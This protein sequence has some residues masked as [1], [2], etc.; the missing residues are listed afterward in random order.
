MCGFLF[1]AVRSWSKIIDNDLSRIIR[2]VPRRKLGVVRL[3]SKSVA[4]SKARSTYTVRYRIPSVRQEVFRVVTLPKLSR[5]AKTRH[6]N[7]S[8]RGGSLGG[9]ASNIT[10]TYATQITLIRRFTILYHTPWHHNRSSPLKPASV[11]EK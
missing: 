8:G 2:V 5:C 7:A 11:F 10:S 6:V 9:G 1:Q 4:G 3:L